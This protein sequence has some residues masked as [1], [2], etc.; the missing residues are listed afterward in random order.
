MI[1][2]VRFRHCWS[3]RAVDVSRVENVCIRMGSGR[4]SLGI[5]VEVIHA[6]E[7]RQSGWV[8]ENEALW[9]QGRCGRWY[10]IPFVMKVEVSGLGKPGDSGVYP[11]DHM[12]SSR[13]MSLVVCLPASSEGPGVC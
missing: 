12:L 3:A 13:S 4:G 8:E 9:W 1:L 10:C 11:D 2:S 5:E 6:K 7:K